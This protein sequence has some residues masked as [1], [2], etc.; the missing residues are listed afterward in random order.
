MIAVLFIPT[1][2]AIFLFARASGSIKL[3]RQ[4]QVREEFALANVRPIEV[5]KKNSAEKVRS[6]L[7]MI[8]AISVLLALGSISIQIAADDVFLVFLDKFITPQIWLWQPIVIGYCMIA[9]TLESLASN[10]KYQPISLS[11]AIASIILVS[12]VT[13]ALPDIGIRSHGVT[14]DALVLFWR[15][16]LFGG[17]LLFTLKTWSR[18]KMRRIESD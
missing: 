3:L 10:T 13:F 17:I 4:P 11:A 1:I 6:L 14:S 15:V 2:I 9:R 18:F 12:I 5:Y 8:A 16:I 7:K